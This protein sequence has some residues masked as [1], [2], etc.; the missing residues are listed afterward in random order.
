VPVQDDIAWAATD[1]RAGYAVSPN[2]TFAY[3]RESE[4]NN[5]YTL[6]WRDRAGRDSV[7]IGKPGSYSEPRLSPNGRWIALTLERP[8]RD[9]WLYDVARGGVPTQLTRAPAYAFNAVWMQDSRR[10]VY[11]YEDRVYQLHI[12][13]VDA[14]GSD[15]TLMQTA[16]DKYATSVSTDGSKLLFTHTL[17][18]DRVMITPF[19]EN[20]AS[21]GIAE[22]TL[23]QRL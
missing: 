11:T 14:S 15:E 1:G 12:M 9:I 20:D 3:L 18:G 10:I 5:D 8:K 6:V 19:G 17:F 22:G 2:G 13:P 7:L 21:V 4:W 23:E 16:F